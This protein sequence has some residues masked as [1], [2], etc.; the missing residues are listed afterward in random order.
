MDIISYIISFCFGSKNRV[1]LMDIAYHMQHI[2]TPSITINPSMS[3]L[4]GSAWLDGND[5]LEPCSWES[6]PNP[7]PNLTLDL[8]LH[9]GS[10]PKCHYLEIGI[11]SWIPHE[12]SWRWHRNIFDLWVEHRPT[13]YISVQ[14]HRSNLI[15]DGDRL[16]SMYLA[17]TSESA[18]RGFPRIFP[19]WQP[20]GSSGG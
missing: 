16:C 4:C 18:P 20:A 7:N 11:S 15:T 1:N 13:S 3:W 10:N 2:Y 6:N 17:I 14:W 19:S 8:N 5:E 9:H 12:A